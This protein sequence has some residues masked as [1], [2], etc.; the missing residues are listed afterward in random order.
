MVLVCSTVAP[1][2]V[3]MVINCVT[4]LRTALMDLMKMKLFAVSVL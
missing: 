3:L 4:G 1:V 2:G